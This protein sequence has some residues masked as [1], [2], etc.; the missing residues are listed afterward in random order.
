MVAEPGDDPRAR[1]LELMQDLRVALP[2]VQ[3]LFAFLLGLPFTTP[4]AS[5][6]GTP[7]RIIYFVA[8]ATSALATVLMIAP[9]AL[10]RM[11]H[12]LDDPGG[13][14]PLVRLANHLAIMGTAFLAVSMAAVVY[15][16]TELLFH[17][18]AAAIVTA[19]LALLSAWFW[20]GFP[21]FER[22]RRRA[23]A[24]DTGAGR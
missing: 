5:A 22:A 13:L 24:Q 6:I 18:A 7:E 4:F 21:I 16:V 15:L 20:F 2:G 8:F 11:Y 9:S 10:H 1:L 12:A 17:V 3:V 19:I 23:R 14:A